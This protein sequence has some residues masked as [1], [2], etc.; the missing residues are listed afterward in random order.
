MVRRSK[1]R[2]KTI[3]YL[4]RRGGCEAGDVAFGAPE[5][6]FSAGAGLPEVPTGA[7]PAEAAL[8]GGCPSE[9]D[10]PIIAEKAK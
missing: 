4:I 3:R 10:G 2:Q 5:E 8:A 6:A 9:V 7:T 1:D